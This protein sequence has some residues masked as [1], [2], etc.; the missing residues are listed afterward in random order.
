VDARPPIGTAFI[1]ER[2]SRAKAADG[3]VCPHCGKPLKK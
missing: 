3:D 2:Q 1:E